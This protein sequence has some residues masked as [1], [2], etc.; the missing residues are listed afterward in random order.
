[1]AAEPS[2][3]RPDCSRRG[4]LRALLCAALACAGMAL[5]SCDRPPLPGVEKVRVKD[6]TFWLDPALDDATRLKGLGGRESLPPDGGMLFVFPSSFVQTFVMRDC[7]FDIDIA[8]LDDT[9]R[10]TAVHTMKMDPR[11]PGESDSDYERR[12][13]K[14]SSNFPARFAVE[15]MG[16]TLQRLG[17][18]PGEVVELDV[19]GLKKRAR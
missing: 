16:G 10:V 18:K 8:F 17:L 12:L 13:V 19:D 15:V 9:G 6:A 2:L 1:M 3:I 7:N 5:T 4:A 11:R 14:Y